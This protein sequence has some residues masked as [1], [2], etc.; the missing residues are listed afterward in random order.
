M[1]LYY[2]IEV[3]AEISDRPG[4]REGKKTIK[5]DNM[6]NQ[7]W[8]EN[9]AQQRIVDFIEKM[10]NIDNQLKFKK[11]YLTWFMQCNRWKT[12]IIGRFLKQLVNVGHIDQYHFLFN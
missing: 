11:K 5:I 8:I 12:I 6:L 9:K 4:V 10:D 3:A 1:Y 7:E 2:S